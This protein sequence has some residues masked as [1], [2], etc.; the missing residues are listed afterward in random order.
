MASLNVV[1][2]LN[3]KIISL[4]V[5][6]VEIIQIIFT[7]KKPESEN[8]DLLLVKKNDSNQLIA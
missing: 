1:F 3:L 7:F 6:E 2:V 4:H 8:S 5:I